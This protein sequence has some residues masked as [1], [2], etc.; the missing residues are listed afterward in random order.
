MLVARV[1]SQEVDPDVWKACAGV[2]I[3]VPEV[4]SKVYY[5]PQGHAE[6]CHSPV[7]FISPLVFSRPVITCRVD[8]VFKFASC[9]TDEVYVTYQLTPI[10][11]T[12]GIHLPEE[13]PDGGGEEEE[14]VV[15]FGKVLT[16][17]DTN[18]GGVFSVPRFCAESIFPPVDSSENPPVQ[19]LAIKDV[20][21]VVWEFRHI[22]RGMPR[23]H[24]LTTGWSKFVN[25]KRLTYGDTVLFMKKPTTGEL[26]VGVK[27]LSRREGPGAGWEWNS[28]A[29]PVTV[30][31]RRGGTGR[32]SVESVAEAAEL[33]AKGMPFQVVYFPRVGS[34]AFVVEAEKVEKSLTMFW[35]AGVRIQMPVEHEDCSKV[36]WFQGT[37][38]KPYVS[39]AGP[40][41]P[42]PWRMLQVTWDRSGVLQNVRV[43]P[44][45]V[46]LVPPKPSLEYST[47]R[48]ARKKLRS[49]AAENPFSPGSGSSSSSRAGNL[50]TSMILNQAE[51]ASSGLRGA[52]FDSPAANENIHQMCSAESFANCI[53]A[54]ESNAFSVNLIV[55][56]PQQCDSLSPNIQSRVHAVGNE[57]V[58]KQG[59]FAL[60]QLFG[61]IIYTKD[62][63]ESG[64]IGVGCAQDDGSQ[65]FKETESKPKS[66]ELSSTSPCTEQLDEKAQ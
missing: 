65:M 6:H 63:V 33:A 10:A 66:F 19:T 42:S 40:W 30:C 12:G 18:I 14:E 20:H 53:M 2:G 41:F 34:L 59:D 22:Y 28:P 27:R 8:C 25:K 56:S 45:E 35:A 11:P 44:W 21:N 50:N 60:F 31:S 62:P 43:N 49:I 1:E 39:E 51:S 16:I 58:G 26:F 3:T 13:R 36:T 47:P 5:F 29:G 17:S 55:A 32:L 24:L 46:K 7:T 52:K 23:R 15:W 38:S 37:V 54:P 4:G 9:L 48:P 57:L 64:S 61:K